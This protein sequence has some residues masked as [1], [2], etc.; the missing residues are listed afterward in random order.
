MDAVKISRYVAITFSNKLMT[1]AW[2]TG[3][4]VFCKIIYYGKCLSA[5]LFNTNR[6]SLAL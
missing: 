5:K 4:K 6:L 3:L 2:L 1:N